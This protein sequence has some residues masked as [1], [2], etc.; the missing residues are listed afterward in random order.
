MLKI[1]KIKSSSIITKSNL[2]E[3]DYVINPYVGRMHRCFYCYAR[4]YSRHSEVLRR[5]P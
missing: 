1:S 3:A 2:P 5:I 4:F